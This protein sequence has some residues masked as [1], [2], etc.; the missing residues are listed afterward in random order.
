MKLLKQFLKSEG[1]Y[2]GLLDYRA[3][4]ASQR[5]K[6]ILVGGLCA[7]AQTVFLSCLA[8]DLPKQPK[9][10]I[11]Q[12]EKD[13]LRTYNRLTSAGL[14][15]AVYPVRDFMLHN[16][17]ASHEYEQNRLCALAGVVKGTLDYVIATPDAA[18]QYTMPKGIFE[19]SAFTFKVGDECSLTELA[20][21]L[22]SCGYVR[23]DAVDNI[24]QFSI[25]GGICDIFVPGEDYPHRMELFG[26]EIDSIGIFDIITQRR[27]E[28][29]SEFSVFPAREIVTND[30]S[31]YAIVNAISAQLK[32]TKSESAKKVL[33]AELDCIE[34]GA[35]LPFIDKYINIVYPNPE[36]LFDYFGL[37]NEKGLV[38]IDNPSGVYA[39]LDSAE[40][41]ALQIA[42]DVVESEEIASKYA[43]YSISKADCKYI[44]ESTASLTLDFFGT[45]KGKYYEKY[46]FKTKNQLS[47][48]SSPELLKEDVAHYIRFGYA[49]ILL[50]ENE[51]VGKNYSSMLAEEGIDAPVC[52]FGSIDA[53]ISQLYGK[54]VIMYGQNHTGF[55]IETCRVACISLYIAQ[56]AYSKISRIKGS[57]KGKKI[58]AQEKIM[59]Y[60]DLTVGDYVVH[61]VHGIGLYEGMKNLTN[62]EGVSRDF[63]QVKYADGAMLYVP[64]DRLDVLSKYIGQRQS[65]GSV[66]L[67]KMGGTEW[68]RAKKKVSAAVREMAKEL[69]ALYAKRMKKEGY[70]FSKDD[71]LQR[72]FEA[73]FEY[74]ETDGQLAAASDIKRD[75]QSPHPMDRLLCGDVGFGKTEVALRAAFKAA[76]EG[77]QVAVLVPTTILA[78]QHYQ[79][80]CARMRGFALNVDVLSRFRTAKETSEIL[81]KLKRGDIDIIIG[82]HRLI[83]QDVEFRDLGLI[84]IDEEQRFGVAHK[85]KLKMISENADVLTLTATPIPRTLNMALGGIR[86][87]SVLDEPPIDRMPPQTYVTEYD[88]EIITEAIRKELRRGGQVFYLH[89]NVEDIQRTAYKVSQMAPDANIAI[90]HGK[91]DK[92]ELSDVWKSVIEGETDILVCTT[93]IETGVDVPNANTL[94]IEN[95]DRMGL[96]QLHQI[97]GRIGRSSRRAYAYLTYKPN[98]ALSE[99][100]SK[101]LNAIREYTE[102]G[103]GFKI[104]LR[105]LEI[106]GAG[107]IL[108]AEQHG[109]I[110]SV[111]YDMYIKLLNAAVVEES[112]GEVK[113]PKTECTVD[114][115]FSAFIPDSYI[116]SSQTRI[117]IYKKISHIQ[118]EADLDDVADEML[119]RFG[120]LPPSV[121]NLLDVSYIRALGEQLGAR[122]IIQSEGKITLLPETDALQTWVNIVSACRDRMVIMPGASPSVVYKIK[123][124][125]RPLAYLK[126]ALSAE[127]AKKSADTSVK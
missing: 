54:A 7:G 123:K 109:H 58:S 8:D 4:M 67:N 25:R 105:D 23:V 1:E 101:R 32:K 115:K 95:A 24:A 29:R 110:E 111:G 108:G 106:R 82:T 19:K 124:G 73:S 74:E 103:S 117:E 83:S 60:A 50:C 22:V 12:D 33:N 96:S 55:I 126:N 100:A 35:E 66:K 121:E 31:I 6:P 72:Q 80:I 16:I 104:A 47:Y 79:T 57:R 92:E 102:F 15:C 42:T 62:F 118:T 71:D 122:K 113:K 2:K 45:H 59:S 11:Q 88:E 112:G 98:V 125:D 97:R 64:C 9:L 81:R 38:V 30:E 84:I 46:T 94:I 90:A 34:S 43:K 99:I 44:F 78:M 20:E 91:M 119:D 21:S 52:E 18:S 37:K 36:T 93:I 39:R 127:A 49:V 26:D 63:L 89:N 40:K 116:K 27:I 17:T 76:A 65:D 5:P 61:D 69:I 107:N 68:G 51:T 14:C 56:S 10:I 13:C 120:D 3:Q 53:S 70:A 48:A 87:M 77:K 86:D 28:N 75:M 114:L 85:E 41:M